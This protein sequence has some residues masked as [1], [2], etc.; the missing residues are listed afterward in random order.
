MGASGRIGGA[1]AE[2]LRAAGYAVSM[3]GRDEA[4]PERGWVA[5]VNAVGAGMSS[6]ARGSGDA[7]QAANVDVALAAAAHAR[8]SGARL[9]HIGTV[10]ER[11]P[12]ATTGDPYV[13]SKLTAARALRAQ[14]ADLDL[15]ELWPH[16]VVGGSGRTPSLVERVAAR[17]RAG[18]PFELRTPYV[19]RDLV[20][21]AD[22][23]RAV[24]LA[25]ASETAPAEPLE[26]G[27][28]S[29]LTMAELVDL[30]RGVLG[31]GHGW[32]PSQGPAPGWSGDLVADPGPA[33]RMLGFT[34]ERTASDALLAALKAGQLDTPEKESS[35]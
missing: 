34:A 24:A 17:L 5:V 19:R 27:T 3:P 2:A 9:V 8:R 4:W 31:T 10:L 7:L 20:H 21:A 30:V 32:V 33:A 26:I 23:G 12:L 13:A 18:A 29:S 6:D 16:L 22:I 11:T 35:A 14:R 15:I 28:G 1:A 25:V